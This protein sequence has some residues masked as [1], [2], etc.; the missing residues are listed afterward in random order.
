MTSYKTLSQKIK[1]FKSIK[2]TGRLG[3]E[4]E[5]EY[6]ACAQLILSMIEKD[7]QKRPKA[8]EIAGLECFKAWE[9][10]VLQ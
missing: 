10:S 3:Q 2:E 8:C 1:T 4:F 5:K 7:P 9:K 6:P